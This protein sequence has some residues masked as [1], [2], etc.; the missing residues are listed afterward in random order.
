MD[1]KAK[2]AAYKVKRTQALESNLASLKAALSWA[3]T[4]DERDAI[5]TRINEVK[6]LLEAK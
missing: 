3:Q 6:A 5:I 2:L 1:A 4:D